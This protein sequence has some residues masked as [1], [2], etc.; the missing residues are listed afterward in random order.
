MRI[1]DSR[2]LHRSLK[3]DLPVAVS[4]AGVHLIDAD[5]RDYID[6][7]GGAAVSCL[8]HSHP[9]PIAAIRAQAEKLAYAHTAF[10]TSEPAELLAADL[11]RRAPAGFDRGQLV[12]VAD[13]DGFGAGR[14]GGG[15]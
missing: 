2:V 12:F 3:D 6:A 14:G 5:G 13:Q 9:A 11:M 10:F 7:S 4:G 8:G 1:G 15:Q